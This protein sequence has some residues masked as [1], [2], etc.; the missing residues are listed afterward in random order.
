MGAASQQTNTYDAQYGRTGGGVIN[1]TLK[2][3]TNRFHGT[4]WDYVRYGSWDANNTLNNARGEPRPPHQ[5]NQYGAMVNGPSYKDKTFFML[6]WEGLRERVPFPI[7]TSVPTLA[8]RNGDFCQSYSD[9]RTPLVIYDPLTTRR[10]PNDPSKFIRDPL[11][12][13]SDPNKRRIPDPRINPIAQ[14]IL[15]IYPLPNV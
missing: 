8:E 3:G 13:C 10:D 15:Q 14:K 1:M 11:I 6:T 7:R 12:N 4:L 2:S 9:Q 5:Y